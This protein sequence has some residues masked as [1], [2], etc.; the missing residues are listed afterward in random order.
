M[1]ARRSKAL[2]VL[3]TG[4]VV[5]LVTVFVLFWA[6]WGCEYV[7]A[8]LIPEGQWYARIDVTALS[9]SG[10]L[11]DANGNPIPQY[12]LARRTEEQKLE[13]ALGIV[14]YQREHEQDAQD[15][16]VYI[17]GKS[18]NDVRLYYDRALGMIVHQSPIPVHQPD[19]SYRTTKVVDY[20]GPGGVG[21][22]PDSKLGR[23]HDPIVRMAQ[24]DHSHPIV[25]DPKLRRFFAFEIGG[26]SVRQGPAI[27]AHLPA[28]VD[29]GSPQKQ[30][31]AMELDASGAHFTWGRNPSRALV[32][33]AVG[34][35]RMLNLDTLT[36]DYNNHPLGRLPAPATLFPSSRWMTPDDLFA[37]GV[38]PLFSSV[39]TGYD[40]IVADT[41]AGCAVAVLSRD[42]TAMRVEVFDANGISVGT[43]QVVV[44]EAGRF[45]GD[46]AGVR[47]MSTVAALYFELP[48]AAALTATK[49]VLECLHPPILL[50]LSYFTT[51]GTEAVAGH[52]AMF[53][54]PDSL[55]A[56]KARSDESGPISRFIGSLLFLMPGVVLGTLLA[57][58]VAREGRRMGLPVRARRLWMAAMVV[59][60]LPAYMTYRMTR[61]KMSRVTCRN[62]G[63]DRWVDREKCHH[64]GSPWVVPEL[65][66][67]AWRVIG[68][69][70]ESSCNDPSLR[71]EEKISE[72]HNG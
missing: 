8:G 23:F 60:A 31:R 59:F 37:Y 24:T 40:E 15:W 33:D 20:I 42:A 16:P 44:G 36:L 55:A 62:C 52:R 41:Y 68:R 38:L 71:P 29:F 17:W 6:R 4:V 46:F 45:P 7:R 39:L 56:M 53:V 65:V 19:G 11:A 2:G 1:N 64:C 54:L 18:E 66:P 70:E 10:G 12:V 30:P 63:R 26:K 51:S 34:N 72:K 67:P 35:F 48:G 5:L 43:K 28:P 58:A 61:P 50:W 21:D 57:V 27:P 14:Q 47:P 25:Y 22:R 9:R 3:A 32:L 49:Y 13:A 69:P